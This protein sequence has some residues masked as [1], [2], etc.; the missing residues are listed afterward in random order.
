MLGELAE[1]GAYPAILQELSVKDRESSIFLRVNEG[2]FS[3]CLGAAKLNRQ[4]VFIIHSGETIWLHHS[5]LLF[6]DDKTTHTSY[7]S[8]L[9]Y[10]NVNYIRNVCIKHRSK[11][12]KLYH[13]YASLR[14][15]ITVYTS[16]L[17]LCPSSAVYFTHNSRYM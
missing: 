1:H 10:V 4:T 3:R 2:H 7:K 15:S 9:Y 12:N 5:S 14:V 6:T 17:A 8:H 11:C 16:S 13:N